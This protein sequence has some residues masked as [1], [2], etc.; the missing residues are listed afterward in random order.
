[1][2]ANTRVPE[3]HYRNRDGVFVSTSHAAARGMTLSA[4]STSVSQSSPTRSERYHIP[5]D[6][7][8]AQQRPGY[9][10]SSVWCATFCSPTSVADPSRPCRRGVVRWAD[11]EGLRRRSAA[12]RPG[13]GPV[14]VR[15]A[16]GVLRW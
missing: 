3:R 16:A 12:R 5:P 9:V 4:T 7:V 13:D 6:Q 10:R 2:G 1:M 15:L 11:R 8:R 14:V